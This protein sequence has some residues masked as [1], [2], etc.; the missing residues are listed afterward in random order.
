MAKKFQVDVSEL[1]K[2]NSL[3]DPKNIWRGLLISLSHGH[4]HCGSIDRMESARWVGLRE[5][6]TRGLH[7][8]VQ[9]Q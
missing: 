5:D 6:C 1:Q 2:I 4:E 3:V 7:L 9:L 8:P